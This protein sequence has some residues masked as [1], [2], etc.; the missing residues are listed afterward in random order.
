MGEVAFCPQTKHEADTAHISHN[1]YSNGQE[2]LKRLATLHSG[3]NSVETHPTITTITQ[4]TQSCILRLH[5][6]EFKWE[7][8]QR[9]DMKLPPRR[10]PSVLRVRD[11]P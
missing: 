9:T 4:A 1:T 6:G 10:R 5:L 8:R 11:V 7:E 2:T 3:E